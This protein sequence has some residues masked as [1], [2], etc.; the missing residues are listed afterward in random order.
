MSLLVLP[1]IFVSFSV[2]N[3]EVPVPSDNPN[4]EEM[5]SIFREI[6][7]EKE[8]DKNGY[9]DWSYALHAWNDIR[10]GE[11]FD[12]EWDRVY[13]TYEAWKKAGEK[14]PLDENPNADLIQKG[15][16]LDRAYSLWRKMY[17][18]WISGRGLRAEPWNQNK[19]HMTCFTI[20]VMNVF[21]RRCDD[22]PDWRTDE[23]IAR[24]NKVLKDYEA[25]QA[26]KAAKAAQ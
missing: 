23:D 17:G 3:A 11:D 12:V 1:A 15:H 14:P 22:L 16:D 13:P 21:T 4:I 20:Q 5:E 10:S 7:K 9:Y 6:E 24:D 8:K 2:A 18:S 25:R 26:Q 19:G